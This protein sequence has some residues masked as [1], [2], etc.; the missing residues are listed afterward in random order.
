MFNWL[1]KKSQNARF[2]AQITQTHWLVD[3]LS[4]LDRAHALIWVG[5]IIQQS[6]LDSWRISVAFH[7][8]SKFPRDELLKLYYPL[9]EVRIKVQLQCEQ[10]LKGP[11][12]AIM[13]DEDKRHMEASLHAWQIILA[14]L[15][16][17][18]THD[19]SERA[20]AM[21]QVLQTAHS[22]LPPAMNRYRRCLTKMGAH[23]FPFSDAECIS[24]AKTV[25]DQFTARSIE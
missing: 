15:A 6:L 20:R 22:D 24:H 10:T 14:T 17:G 9:E 19:S 23:D 5:V 16:P 11:L 7:N 18:L 25:P 3:E 8:P 4:A 13:P 2:S 1:L 12:A 21:W